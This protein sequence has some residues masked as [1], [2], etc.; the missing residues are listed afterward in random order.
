VSQ[1]RRQRRGAGHRGTLRWRAGDSGARPVAP[2]CRPEATVMAA[3]NL[4]ARIESELNSAS[5]AMPAFRYINKKQAGTGL[6]LRLDQSSR[7]DTVNIGSD[8]TAMI[9]IE[10]ETKWIWGQT[11]NVL[12]MLDGQTLDSILCGMRGVFHIEL[13]THSLQAK[14]GDHVSEII[15]FRLQESDLL[16]F[17]CSVTGIFRVRVA[18]RALFRRNVKPQFRTPNE[19]RFGR[20][21]NDIMPW[22]EVLNVSHDASFE[23]I[24]IAYKRLVDEFRF[25]TIAGMG[26]VD[27]RYA[28]SR[29]R[30]VN[31]AY[32]EAQMLRW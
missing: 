23:E 1:P 25:K 16:N 17:R 10:T 14:C 15:Y 5:H 29:I 26:E 21:F 8:V 9:V 28:L 12:M 2:H 13:G 31:E 27:K 18:L 4:W 11:A 32:A 20:R 7:M 6:R 30:K 3:A 19:H 24:T 22:Y